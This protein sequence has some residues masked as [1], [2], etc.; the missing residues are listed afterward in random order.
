M[1][2]VDVYWMSDNLRMKVSMEGVSTVSGGRAFESFTVSR[3]VVR[4]RLN[5]IC[6]MCPGRLT[7][8]VLGNQKSK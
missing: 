1:V 2:G 3:S 7:V 6:S 8:I 4:S 5:S